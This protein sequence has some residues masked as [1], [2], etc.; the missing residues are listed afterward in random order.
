MRLNI[1][2]TAANGNIM[3]TRRVGNRSETYHLRPTANGWYTP[4]AKR[5]DSLR[6]SFRIEGNTLVTAERAIIRSPLSHRYAK[7][8]AFYFLRI[9][10]V[11]HLIAIIGR[12]LM[13]QKARIA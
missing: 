13:L 12:F 1:I 6:I 10:L 7:V 4:S 8:R 3:A 11:Q 5:F 2:S 9:K